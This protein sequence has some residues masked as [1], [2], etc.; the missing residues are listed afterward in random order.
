MARPFTRT[1]LPGLLAAL[2]S[3]VVP[4][5]PA[6][7]SPPLNLIVMDPL[8]L[9]LSC[10]CI[11]GLGQ[12]RYDLLA[13]HLQPFIGRSIKVTFDESLALA[14]SRTGGRADVIVGKDA[15]VRSDAGNARL[16]VRPLAALT[17]EEGATQLRGVFLV[18]RTSPAKTIA[19]LVGRT[20]SLG[21]V[22]EEEAHGAVERTLKRLNTTAQ[23]KTAR[24]L[25]DAAL[26]MNDGE[27]DAAVVS[28]FLPRL[29]EGCG[30]LE[31]GSVRMIG[32]TDPVPFIR[33]FATATVAP[34]LEE[35]IARGLAAV[36]G[37]PELL[38]ALES[39]A[40]FV[41]LR[42]D[43]ITAWTDWRGPGR[44]GFVP[45]LPR[46]FPANPRKIWSSPLT[47]PALAG[48]AATEQFVVVPDKSA[49][50]KWDIFRG[51]SARD[52][53]ELWHLQY[54]APDSLEYSNV[55]RAM[56]VIHDGLVYLQGALGHLHCVE[57]ATGKVIWN[58][59]LF[60]DFG[61]TLLTWGA[62]LPPL[63][64]EDKLIVAPGARDASVVALDRKTG[65]VLWKSPGHA[66]AYGAFIH[67]TFNGVD[68]IIGYDVVSLGGWNPT[69]GQRL[70]TITPTDGADFNVTT[71]VLVGQR[72]LLATENNATR[73]YRFD[74]HG[75]LNPEPELKNNDLAPDTCTPAV[76]NGRIFA[77]AYGEL[78]CLDLNDQLKTLWRVA[79]DMFQD[80]TNIV[81]SKD[82]VL[83]W[84]MSGDLLLLDA[85]ASHYQVLSHLRPFPGKEIDSAAHPAFVGDRI[86]LRSSQELVG[87]RLTEN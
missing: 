81:G 49:D 64:V 11:A 4:P 80:H 39:K 28:D 42:Q 26:A 61:A 52:G 15:V 32:E 13:Q 78:F 63:V 51:L 30:K 8:A 76:V 67:G 37:K 7:E 44:K 23:L 43:V 57:L 68:Q 62:C 9:P 10:T 82:R 58:T 66:G 38:A 46:R 22:E 1:A 69:T 59:H 53:K 3:L 2:L 17:D 70:W 20:I 27:A 75:R 5:A 71:P 55:P 36:A 6:A 60:A 45:Q 87:L 84:T 14:T 19:D 33:V 29:L 25:D 48:C 21:P 74:G 16:A 24:S 65:Q 73:L 86:Y 35:K 83:I 56:P 54:D 79:D 40:G 34:D 31:R 72:V 18:R 12:R 77:T 47:G 85:A 50:F 41:D